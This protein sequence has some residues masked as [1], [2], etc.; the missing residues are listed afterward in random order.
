[1][2]VAITERL[3][4]TG[5]LRYTDETKDYLVIQSR[6]VGTPRSATGV[7]GTKIWTPMVNLAWQATDD[8]LLYGTYSEGYRAGGFAARF[9]GGLI[10]PLPSYDPEYVSSYEAGL[11]STLF[12]RRLTLNL[13]AFRMNYRDIQVT[14]TTPGL[15]GFVLNLADARYTGFE[16]EAQARLGGGFTGTFSGSYTKKELTKV[17]PGTVSSEGTNAVVPITTDSTLPGPAWQLNGGLQHRYQFDN[18]GR[19]DSSFDVHYESRDSNSVA[20]YDIIVQKGYA[21]A[22]AR[23]AYT[24]PEDR[25][26]LAIGARNLF[27]ERYFTTKTLSSSSG[28]VFGTLARPREAYVQFTY[29]FGS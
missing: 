2:T 27:D 14:A 15:A 22:N 7:Q 3:K 19:L 10:S 26:T 25:F 6:S 24:W 12:D 11:K 18:G 21:E 13:A 4:L 23:V 29:R 20:N 16:L 8:L 9:S 5:G 17:A 28:A 1:M